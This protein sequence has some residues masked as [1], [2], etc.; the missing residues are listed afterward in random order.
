LRQ[1]EAW[2]KLRAETPELQAR[3]AFRKD[4][5][6]LGQMGNWEELLARLD[7]ARVAG[8][9]PLDI[10][11]APSVA[12]NTLRPALIQWTRQAVTT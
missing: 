10:G 4:I 9:P 5:R 6:A 8:E 7:A 12:M 2:R 11:E 1:L 3:H